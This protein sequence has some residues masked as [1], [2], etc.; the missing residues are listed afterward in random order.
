MLYGG[1]GRNVLIS[2]WGTNFLVG[3]SGDNLLLGNPTIYNANLAAPDAILSEWSSG[4]SLAIE[5]SKLKAGTGLA[6]GYALN[7]QTVVNDHTTDYL[8]GGSGR[9]WSVNYFDTDT[10]IGC[11]SWKDQKN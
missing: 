1:S 2:G 7:A 5:I 3:G 10:I 6:A 4:D 9:N 11:W 8:L